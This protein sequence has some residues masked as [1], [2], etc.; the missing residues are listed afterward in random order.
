M[1][2]TVIRS[3]PKT[4]NTYRSMNWRNTWRGSSN[5]SLTSMFYTK[6]QWNCSGGL[7]WSCTLLIHLFVLFSCNL[8]SI[9]HFHRGVDWKDA[10]SNN[11]QQYLTH[12]KET[13]KINWSIS[14]TYSC[15]GSRPLQVKYDRVYEHMGI[16]MTISIVILCF[17]PK[18]GKIVSRLNLDRNST[19]AS[20]HI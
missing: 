1:T 17:G 16:I 10:E 14:M 20:G 19:H 11:F 8:S 5:V 7:Y 13:F 12:F 4:Q 9:Y 2:F 15:L 3:Q 6:I 18:Y